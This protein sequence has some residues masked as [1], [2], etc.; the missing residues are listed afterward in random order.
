MTIIV[1]VASLLGQTLPVGNA[2]ALRLR[3]EIRDSPIVDLDLTIDFTVKFSP[4]YKNQI[5]TL[6]EILKISPNFLA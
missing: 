4:T 1:G 5:N 2:C 6:D 3:K